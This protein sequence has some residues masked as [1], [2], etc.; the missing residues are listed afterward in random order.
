[1]AGHRWSHVLSGH[2]SFSSGP[3]PSNVKNNDLRAEHSQAEGHKMIGEAWTHGLD[4]QLVSSL[5]WD[6]LNHWDIGMN[7]NKKDASRAVVS[8]PKKKEIR[9]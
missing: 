7:S 2:W 8:F 9:M 4:Q 3:L 1:M 6:V 5:F